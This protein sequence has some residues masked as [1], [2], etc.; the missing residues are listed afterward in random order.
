MPAKLARTRKKMRARFKGVI[1]TESMIKTSFKFA[2]FGI[3][4]TLILLFLI[5]DH[6]ADDYNVVFNLI[7]NFLVPAH[8]LGWLSITPLGEKIG[9]FLTPIVFLVN[10]I[11][12]L[13]FGLIFSYF[14]KKSTI[15]GFLLATTLHLFLVFS[16]GHLFVCYFETCANH[17][18]LWGQ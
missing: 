5:D 11:F 10:G 6:L 12:W 2:L 7:S 16:F 18:N 14:K 15:F 8:V 1:F 17:W 9:W 13:I 4:S 3:V